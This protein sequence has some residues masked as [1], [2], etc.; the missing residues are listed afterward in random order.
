MK[1]TERA[2]L[3][4]TCPLGDPG[5]KPLTMPQF[6]EL[7]RRMQG[8][9][10]EEPDRELQLAD[11]TAMGY[12]EDFARHILEILDDETVLNGYLSVGKKLGIRPVTRVSED[13]PL[14]LRKRL[15]LDAPG[16]LWVRGDVSLLEKPAVAL[17]GSRELKRENRAFAEEAGRQAALQGLTLVSGNARGADRT[18]QDACLEAG[19]SLICVTAD[20]LM[21]HDIRENVLYISETGYEIPFSAQRALSRNR[22]IHALG[23]IT[24]VAQ[25]T[26]HKGGTWD[27]TVKN[28]RHGWSPVACFRDG[29]QAAA[30]LEQLRAY[31]IGMEDLKDFSA[32]AD[33]G[34]SSFF[35]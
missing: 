34:Q 30:E 16:V 18:A 3:L 26:L 8:F 22:V 7:T 28:L 29:S 21:E 32:L 33:S 19:G 1:N 5:R 12:G 27:G 23:R 15:G 10:C 6:R 24:L 31:G 14:I 35:E 4:L 9:R 2:M 25:A 11:L 17:V 20:A 13:Y